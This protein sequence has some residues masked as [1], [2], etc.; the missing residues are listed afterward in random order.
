M[1]YAQILN[2]K[3]HWIFEDKMTLEE[4]GQTK[5]NLEQI[6]LVDITNISDI[7]EGYDYDGVN[8]ASPSIPQPSQE[9]ILSKLIS[10]VQSYLDSTAKQMGYDGIVSLCSYKGST[11]AIFNKEGTAGVAWRDL[12]WRTCYTIR[13]EV[14]AGT[15][16]IPTVEELISEL[17]EFTWGD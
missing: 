9:E 12:V 7:H 4:I 5:Y 13:D 2:E 14:L 16:T 1:R 6:Q 15:R 11:D 10:G 3:V 17:P 8:F